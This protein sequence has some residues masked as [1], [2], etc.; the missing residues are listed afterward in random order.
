MSGMLQ[1]V[2][3]LTTAVATIVAVGV[4]LW[5]AVRA[6]R[7]ADR[8]DKKILAAENVRRRAQRVE[9]TAERNSL[10]GRIPT[11]EHWLQVEG[12]YKAGSPREAQL[13]A[14][15]RNARDRIT[16]IDAILSELDAEE[17]G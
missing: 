4:S 9:L 16:L 14:E 2:A 3:E 5:V 1:T 6:E 15:F 13:Q 12:S 17:V 8:A 7:R 10:D 11:L